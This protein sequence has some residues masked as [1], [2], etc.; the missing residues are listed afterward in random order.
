[1][2]QKTLLENQIHDLE[3]LKSP[4]LSA[5][6]IAFLDNEIDTRTAQLQL[7]ASGAVPNETIKIKKPRVA[8]DHVGSGNRRRHSYK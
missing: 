8:Y 1:M 5:E 2:D 6:Q 3:G 7:I 4:R